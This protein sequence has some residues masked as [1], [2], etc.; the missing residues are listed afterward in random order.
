MP[1]GLLAGLLP[2]SCCPYSKSNKPGLFCQE[3]FLSFYVSVWDITKPYFDVSS[4]TSSPPP[5]SQ[6]FL[7]LKTPSSGPVQALLPPDAS[8]ASLTFFSRALPAHITHLPSLQA[9]LSC[10]LFYASLL[11][12]E[13]GCEGLGAWG[14]RARTQQHHTTTSSVSPSWGLGPGQ[15]NGKYLLIGC[16]DNSSVPFTLLLSPLGRKEKVIPAALA[17]I[18]RP[19]ALLLS[20][21][22]QLGQLR[23]VFPAAP[24]P[25]SEELKHWEGCFPLGNLHFLMQR[26]QGNIYGQRLSEPTA[27]GVNSL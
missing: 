27:Q 7:F 20:W 13:L 10:W 25:L 4:F 21:E 19:G 12:L 2:P 23:C 24:L 11:L 1:T 15:A 5:S 16:K 26:E 6:P 22:L 18:P 14:Y 8:L 9:A 17:S 3:D